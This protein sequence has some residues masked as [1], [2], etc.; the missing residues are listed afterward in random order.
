[1]TDVSA[2]KN[3]PLHGA[4]Y[5]LDPE[6]HSHDHSACPEAL[7]DLFCMCDKVHGAGIRNQ[8]KL[9]LAA[10]L[11]LCKQSKG[12]YSSEQNSLG[13]CCKDATRGMV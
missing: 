7:Q 2:F 1:M 5:C 6:F 8:G 4:G 11:E 12:R 10:G 9:S 13:Q 3:N